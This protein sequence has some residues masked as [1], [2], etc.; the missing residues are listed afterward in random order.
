MFNIKNEK[1]NHSFEAEDGQSILDAALESGLNFPYGCRNGFCGKCKAL[2]TNGEIDYDG[3]LPPGISAEDAKDGLA[4]LCQC[5]AKSNVDLWVDELDP[6]VASIQVKTLPCKVSEINHLNH[7]VVQV[8]LKTPESDTL[9]YLAGQYIDV[10][11]PDFGLRAFSIANAPSN[12]SML[13]LHI[14]VVEGGE[15]TNFVFNE[16]EAKTLLNIEGTKG[17]FYLRDESDDPIILVA[18]GTGFG[19]VKAMVEHAIKSNTSRSIYIYWGV[20]EQKD[21]YMDLPYEWDKQHENIHFVAVLSEAGEDYQGRKG[22]VHQAVLEDFDDLSTYQIY[23]CGPPIMVES[24][25]KTFVEK[26]MKKDNFFSDAFEFS[27][28]ED[29]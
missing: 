10:I 29:E 15:F 16:L 6:T 2:I 5:S 20:R 14:R 27:A 11:Y 3:D 24:A 13:E 9:Q 26:G 25:A 21:L 17:D 1:T 23:V 12:S 19:P 7:D 22:F 4:L 28:H 18:G 8:F